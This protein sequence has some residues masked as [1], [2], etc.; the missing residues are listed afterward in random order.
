MAAKNSAETI[1]LA[2]S[3]VMR[4]LP[5]DSEI[6]VWD[7]GSVDGTGE[8]ALRAG[9]GKVS[10]IRA[11]MSV[12]SGRARQN[13]LESTDSEFVI[14][15]DSDDVSMPWRFNY[16]LDQMDAAD[17]CFSASFRFSKG[18]LLRKPTL[19]LSYTDRETRTS[20]A[21]HNVLTHSSMVARR[22]VLSMVGGYGDFRLAQD[23]ELWLRAASRGARFRRIGVP[24]LAYRLSDSQVSSQEGYMDRILT[25]PGLFNSYLGLLDS[26]APGGPSRLPGA[27]GGDGDIESLSYLLPEL[28]SNFRPPLRYYYRTLLKKNAY[29]PFHG[30]RSLN[31]R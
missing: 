1:G 8:E 5:S 18:S 23:Y 28:L 6:V 22:S 14:N 31:E 24:C 16:Q 10:V 13:I 30:L 12:G 20:L 3:S 25:Q 2:V 21:F 26:L 9:S 7:D 11:E 27:G 15:M 4:G 19:P 17:F 29:G